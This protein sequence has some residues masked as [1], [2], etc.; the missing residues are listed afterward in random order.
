MDMLE[1]EFKKVLMD[2]NEKFRLLKSA[3]EEKSRSES[4]NKQMLKVTL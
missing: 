2:N 3:F 4:D 1:N